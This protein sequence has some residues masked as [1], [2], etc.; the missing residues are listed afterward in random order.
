MSASRDP[1]AATDRSA[2]KRG[3]LSQRQWEDVREGARIVKQSGVS[4]K[5]HGVEICFDP[6]KT[7]TSF[8]SELGQQQQPR[9][10]LSQSSPQSSQPAQPTQRK[11]RSAQRLQDFQKKK[12]N[13]LLASSWRVPR[14]LRLARWTRVQHVWTAWMRGESLAAAAVEPMEA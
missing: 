4:L 6:K 3:R 11:Q 14:F 5:V 2:A 12:R 13:T 9:R 8:S 10:R 1:R 7:F